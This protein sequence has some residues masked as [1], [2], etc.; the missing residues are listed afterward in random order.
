MGRVSLSPRL[1]CTRPKA[2][3]PQTNGSPSPPK[4]RR[5]RYHGALHSDRMSR[6][7]KLAVATTAV[8]VVLFAVGGLVR[9]SGSGLGCSTWPDC[10]PGK[11]FPRGTIHSMIEFS[12]R[13]LA[14]A[15]I[16]LTFACALAARRTFRDVRA[17]A[18]PALAAFPLALVQAVI[19]GVVVL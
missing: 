14:L 8:T 11:L 10:T 18:W 2:R 9:G 1:L 15:V 5:G 3:W 7:Q 19:G 17:I 6:F 4:G 13:V 12:H 16:M